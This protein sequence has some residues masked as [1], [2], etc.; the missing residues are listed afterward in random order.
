MIEY[1]R[2]ARSLIQYH[3]TPVRSVH[4]Q[5]EQDPISLAQLSCV[6][7]ICPF[8]YDFM[9]LNGEA[10]HYLGALWTKADTEPHTEIIGSD[11]YLCA[12]AVKNKSFFL[13]LFYCY[14]GWF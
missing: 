14:K 8:W 9:E 2:S 5:E 13:Y 12:L 1:L 11:L 10:I 7:T 4:H 6:G 3:L